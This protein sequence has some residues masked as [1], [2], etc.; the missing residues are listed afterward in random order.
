MSLMRSILL[1]ASQNQWLRHRAVNY[2]FVRRT[3]SRFMPGEKLD[4]ALSA[5]HTLRGRKIGTVFTHLGENIKDRGEAQQVA[6]HYCEVLERVRQEGLQAEISVKLTQL[7][8]DLSPELCFQHL[9]GIIGRA[10]KDS[11]VWVDMEA[12]NYVD[13]T[14]DLYRRTLA[15]HPNV[16]V[17]LQ[18]YLHRTKDDLAKLLTLQPSI[19]LVKGAYNEPPEIAFA[20]KQDVDENYFELGKQ[21]LRARKENRCVRAAFG[22]HDVALIRRLADCAWAEGFARRD[23]EVQMLYGIQRAEQEYL[24]REGCTSIVLVAYGS[25]W[26]PWFV[27][28]LA[29]R[30]ANLWF[31]VRN[32]FAA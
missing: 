11:I 13:A 25:Y 12:S 10:Q 21:M 5:A 1:A 24:A 9:N 18:A 31:M 6:D 29:E 19:R 3:V 28:R 20:R 15:T 8:L 26:Y 27:R 32:V 2:P 22:T 14:L 23:F 16:G 7:G 30:P 4:D 17:C